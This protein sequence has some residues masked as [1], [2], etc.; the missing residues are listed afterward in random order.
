[1]KTKSFFR[2]KVTLGWVGRLS[3]ADR[4]LVGS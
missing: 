4:G 2:V 1:M 3:R